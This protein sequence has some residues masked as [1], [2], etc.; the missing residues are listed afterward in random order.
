MYRVLDK[1]RSD[2]LSLLFVVRTTLLLLNYPVPTHIVGKE[3]IP[4]LRYI[5]SPDRKGSSLFIVIL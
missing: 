1:R 3:V 2:I 5:N 4:T